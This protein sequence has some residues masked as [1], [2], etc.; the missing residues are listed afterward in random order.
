ML[1]AYEAPG[2]ALLEHPRV[3]DLY[4]RY[5][6]AASYV[7]LMM[8]P[9]MRTALDRAQALAPEDPVSAGLVPYLKRH[10]V[11]ETHGDELGSASLD[12]LAA[13]GI[14]T[15]AVRTGRLPEKMAALIGTQY[16]RILH[17]HPVAILGLL[18]LEAYPP[19]ASIVERLVE[20][21]GLPREGFSQLLLHSDLDVRHGEEL[22][23][24]VDGLPLEPWHE[25][26]IVLTALQTMSFLIDVWTDIVGGDRDRTPNRGSGGHAVAAEDPHAEVI[27]EYRAQLDGIRARAEQ[28]GTL[29]AAVIAAAITAGAAG[30]VAHRPDWVRVL[31]ALALVAWTGTALLYLHAIMAVRV[32]D[33]PVDD[34][35][36]ALRERLAGVARRAKR[37]VGIA[38]LATRAALVVTVAVL[39]GLLFT[40]RELQ[41]RTARLV[42]SDPGA[43]SV[44]QAC[45][46]PVATTLDADAATSQLNGQY[47]AVRP[48]PADCGKDTI[49][50]VRRSD[51]LA[52]RTARP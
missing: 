6:A 18:W 50:R 31:G 47:L 28:G 10:I 15:D 11:E 7:S 38:F 41:F 32:V 8:V 20:K 2:R 14:D 25:R 40:D 22:H 52:V 23:D 37:D 9:L 33:V 46:R 24:V 44:S 39:L 30:A 51:V 3:G 5:M 45:G 34:P 42:L 13:V 16:F 26:L 29:V 1:P 35:R 4:P 12:D 19:D 17:A 36:D 49:V 48:R 43:R 27:K 21:T